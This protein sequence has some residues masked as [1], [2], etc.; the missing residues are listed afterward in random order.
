MIPSRDFNRESVHEAPCKHM[1]D[2]D[3]LPLLLAISENS[4]HYTSRDTKRKQ[5]HRKRKK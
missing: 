3:I 5:T 4:G 1:S 2:I